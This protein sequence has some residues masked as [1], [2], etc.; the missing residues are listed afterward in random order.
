MVNEIVTYMA[1]EN[2]VILTDDTIRNYLVSGNG[3]ITDQELMMF[4]K[5]CQYQK[6][7]PFLREVYI[8]K[9]GNYP[10][11]TV[12]GKETFLKRA[13]RNPL[14]KGHETGISED[15]KI[16]WAKVYKEGYEV[17]ITCEVDYDEYVGLK[18]GNP[19]KMWASKAR[20]MLKKVALVQALREAFPEDLGG[21]YSPEE[22]NTVTEELTTVEVK[23]P[24]TTQPRYH[25]HRNDYVKGEEKKKPNVAQQAK[26]DYIKNEDKKEPIQSPQNEA[27]DTEGEVVVKITEI[28]YKKGNKKNGQ[29]WK[30]YSITGSDGVVYSTFSDTDAQEAKKAKEEGL[31]VVIIYTPQEFRDK[32]YYNIETLI[33]D[34]ADAVTDIDEKAADAAL[35]ELVDSG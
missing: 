23:Q 31:E 18:D 32:T 8:I 4:K 27:T 15:G 14:Y 35:D 3:K 2:E 16:A 20:T 28:A 34:T 11:A 33:I 24:N 6:L 29:E 12:T 1:G 19:N 7:N 21:L 25:S 5:L 10:A 9:Y 26:E 13:N 30:K 17:P 22:I